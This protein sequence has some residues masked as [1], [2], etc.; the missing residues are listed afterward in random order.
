[1]KHGPIDP[2]KQDFRKFLYVVWKHIGLPDPTPIQ[3]DI[4][5]FLQHGPSKIAIEAFRGVGK[6]FITSAYVLWRLYCNPQ[7]KF[8]VVSASKARADAFSTFTMRLIMEMDILASLRPREEQRQSRIEFDVGPATADQS[9]SVKSVGI[10]GQLTGSRADEIIADDVEVLNN[11]ATADMREKLIE[12]TK[13]FSAILKPLDHA[14]IIYLGTPQTEDSIYNKLPETFEVRIWPALVP[15]KEEGE[16]YGDNLAPFVRRLMD[17]APEGTTTD[18]QR[19]S[20]L[21]LAARQAEYGRAGF[22]LQFML[23]TQLSDEDRYPLK[24]KD[25]IVMDVPKD[26]APMKVNWLPDYKREIKELPNLAMA[27]DRFYMPASHADQFADYTGA[28]MSI[29]PS[30]RGKDETGY[31]VVKM[32][33][34]YLFVTRAGGLQGG[35]DTPTLKQ[36]A[37]IA[38]EESV[39]HIVIE[40][41]FGDGM[42]QALFEPVVSRIHPCAIEEVKHSTQKERRIIDT[43]EPVI[44]RHKLIVDR[45]VIEDDYRTAQKYEADNKFTKTLIYQM[46]R[47]NYD[48]GAL[49][50]DDRLDAL[51]IAVSYWVENMAQDE[52]RGIA[53]EREAALDAELA[54]FMD[55]ASGRKEGANNNVGAQRL[56]NRITTNDR[57]N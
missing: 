45:Q 32:L 53:S 20:D 43:L 33:N 7:L 55:N 49:K 10:T 1:L 18:P 40:A 42:Y 4:A 14:R 35:Y 2:L 34:G 15:T 8:L 46:T 50:H 44:S 38:K 19:F 5:Y 16:K 22:A 12:R 31:A 37:M 23:N 51:A 36:L 30:G 48:R 54:R 13:E 56:F 29:D 17:N 21:D 41:N 3:Y 39:N 27:G 52:D 24:I 28:V 6:S 57:R 11:A 9:P 47:I 25:L 26:K